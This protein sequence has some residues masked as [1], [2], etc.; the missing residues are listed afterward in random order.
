MLLFDRL[1]SF[2]SIQV[3]VVFSLLSG[4][5]KSF[6]YARLRVLDI[7]SCIPYLSVL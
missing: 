3:S 2:Y 4:I 6:A 7:V 1:K 5:E